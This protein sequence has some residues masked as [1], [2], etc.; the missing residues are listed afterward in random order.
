MLPLPSYN[1]Y[2]S[3]MNRRLFYSRAIRF[4]GGGFDVRF[5]THTPPW[6]RVTS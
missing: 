1:S 4:V 6:A 3:N 2:L 5:V